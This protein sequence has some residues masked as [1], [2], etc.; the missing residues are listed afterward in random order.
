MPGTPYATPTTDYEH[1]TNILHDLG[2]LP[3]AAN[4][5]TTMHEILLALDNGLFQTDLATYG[6]GSDGTLNFIASGSTTVA[7][8]TLSSGVYTM[9][10][11]IWAADQTVIQPTVTIKTAGFR[12]FCQGELLN[13]GT[14]QS[15]GNAASANTAG[16]ALSY[17]GTL[18]SG[19]VGTAG[20]AGTSGA[21]ATGVANALS[22]FG[23]AGGVGGSNA[24]I[25]NAGG[26]GGTV[27]GPTAV[28]QLPR[29]AP[30]ATI[31]KLN[32]TTAFLAMGAG[33]GGGSGG[34]DGTNL[35][36]GGGGGGGIVLVAAQ[37]IGGTGTIEAL[38]G[39]GGAAA[40]TGTPSGGGGGGGGLVIVVSRS[41]QPVAVNS[42][43]PLI[44]NQTISVAGGAGGAAPAPGA[45]TVGGVGVSGSIIL[46]PS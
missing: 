24:S 30:Y 19:T 45:G 18:S 41:V 32:N 42:N 12:F 26:S 46:L 36:G 29:S 7:G 39:A 3:T 11:D 21:G 14:I 34:G 10:R 13:N 43:G 25:P 38:G 22:G 35:S 15:N 5:H 31:G 40:A 8:A 28:M 9:T 16:A 33:G 23:G 4:L 1:W 44:L 20:G 17:T 2:S 6:D 37:R 27:T